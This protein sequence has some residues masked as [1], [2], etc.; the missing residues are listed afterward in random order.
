MAPISS[1]E[2]PLLTDAELE[3]LVDLARRA[4]RQH[5][6]FGTYMVACAPAAALRAPGA[7]FVTL[8]Q[9]G[10]LRG[11]IGSLNAHRPL[12]DDVTANALA[13]AFRDPRFKP[14]SSEET[15]MTSVQIAV[16]TPPSAAFRVRGEDEL[17]AQLAPGK[18]G[19]IVR[20][21]SCQA[22][23]LPSVWEQLPAPSDFVGELRRKAGIAA[24]LPVSAL[25]FQRYSTQSSRAISLLT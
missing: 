10:A 11:C 24:T 14:L 8:K 7:S 13:A 21:G 3:W 15:T 18:D 20:H 5:V 19:L 6:E 23:Y 2:P 25:E 16:L 4:V 22:T 1:A 12:A 9:R 17:Y